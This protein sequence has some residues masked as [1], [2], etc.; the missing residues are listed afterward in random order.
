VEA[1][2]DG[3]DA[4]RAR[5]GDRAVDVGLRREVAERALRDRRHERRR[6]GDLDALGGFLARLEGA[7]DLLGAAGVLAGLAR[8]A[9]RFARG[10]VRGPVRAAHEER[11]GPARGDQRRDGD[12][13]SRAA[14]GH[15]PPSAEGE[16]DTLVPR[17][18][19]TRGAGIAP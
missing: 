4:A 8:G 7:A 10:G 17:T 9:R 18:T 13:R 6:E 12:R 15:R 11:D 14:P 1:E 19:R 5:L 16:I 2:L 3:I